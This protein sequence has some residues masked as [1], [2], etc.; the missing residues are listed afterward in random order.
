MRA[1]PSAALVSSRC[2]CGAVPG[3]QRCALTGNGGQ[4]LRPRILIGSAAAVT[5]YRAR[6]RLRTMRGETGSSALCRQRLAQPQVVAA[7]VAN[8][9]VADAVGLVNGLL[10]D[11]RPGGAQRFEGLV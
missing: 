6:E 4:P 10:K 3:E 8:G 2:T 9:S 11:L 5:R 7:G 1:V